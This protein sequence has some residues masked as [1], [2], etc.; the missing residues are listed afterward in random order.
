MSGDANALAAFSSRGPCTD[1]RI[2]PDVVAPGTDIAS[3]KSS[4][5]PMANFLGA[6]PTG[7]PANPS[8]AYD[9]GTSMAAPF[10]AGCA[11]LAQQYYAS[12]KH[13]PS[14]ALIKATL[15]NGTIWLSGGTPTGRPSASPT[16]IRATV[17]STCYDRYRTPAAPELVLFFHDDWKIQDHNQQLSTAGNVI[18]YQVTVRRT[19]RSCASASPTPTCPPAAFKIT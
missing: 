14:A 19:A 1:H 15:V 6:Y 13:D 5:A 4:I 11:A 9:A 10:V 17:A 16:I 3:T 18:R 8:Y 2:K 12:V 7:G